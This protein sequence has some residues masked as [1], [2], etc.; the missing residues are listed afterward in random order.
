MPATKEKFTPS[1]LKALLA[2]KPDK[3]ITVW[4]EKQDGL[5]VL[6]SPGRGDKETRTPT[7]TFRVVYYLRTVPGKP[8]Y[9]K[10][11]RYTGKADEIKQARAD[12]ARIRD[13]AKMKGINPKR[14]KLADKTFEQVVDEFIEDHAKKNRTWEDTRRIF[15]CYVIPEWRGLAIEDIKRSDVMALLRKIAAGKIRQVVERGDKKVTR[16]I[17]TTT[18]ADAALAQIR[19]LMNWYALSTDDYNSPI[20]KGMRRGEPGKRERE[21]SDAEI[22]ALWTATGALGVF[23]AAVRA[24]LLTAQRVQKVEQMRRRDLKERFLVPGHEA[25]DGTWVPDEWVEN[26]WDAARDD[27]PTNKGVSVVPLSAAARAAIDSV[28]IIDVSR[29][30]DYVFSLNGKTPINGRSNSKERLDKLMLA[31]MREQAEA[32]GEDPEAVELRPWELRDLRRTA[33]TLLSRAGIDTDLAER[34][35]AHVKP[36]VRGTYD[37]YNYVPQQRIAFDK[38]AALIARII[39][40]PVGDNVVDLQ[41]S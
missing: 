8:V 41:A 16:M 13:D 10:L 3:Q 34:C 12:A 6:V 28:P 18:N 24:M 25:K 5:C 21:L 4:D 40:P 20:V 7:I 23:G 19:K 26:V 17:G 2:T 33:R 9:K 11:G 38:L 14:P 36:G 27:D 35:L 39:D 30:K 37:R 22:R 1:S 31:A 15:D 32:A 29:G